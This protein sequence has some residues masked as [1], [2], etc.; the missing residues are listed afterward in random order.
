LDIFAVVIAACVGTAKK[1]ELVV[2]TGGT[3]AGQLVDGGDAAVRGFGVRAQGEGFDVGEE[4][5]VFRS[6]RSGY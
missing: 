2:F 1:V 6:F 4:N 3:F 5:R